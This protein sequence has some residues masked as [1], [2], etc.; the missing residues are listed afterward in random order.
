MPLPRFPRLEE[1]LGA[2]PDQLQ[3]QHLQNLVG[4]AAEDADLD[5]KREH[6]GNGDDSKRSLAQDVA[7]LANSRGGLILIGI[8]EINGVASAITPVAL[9]DAE[10]LR[11][12]QIV[13]TLVAPVAPFDMKRVPV[14]GAVDQG[15]LVLAVPPSAQRP[16]AVRV[17]DNLRY[18]SRDGSRNRALAETEVADAYRNRF[19]VA[20]AQVTRVDRIHREALDQL[21]LKDAV[22]LTLALVPNVP[23]AMS[24][25][26][27]TLAEAR[28][29]VEQF[30]CRSQ[31]D[32]PFHDSAIGIGASVRRVTLKSGFE[33]GPASFAY[34]ELHDDGSG[35][36]T[37]EVWHAWN[38]ETRSAGRRDI[39]DEHLVLTMSGLLA[40]LAVHAS[41]NA[42]AYGDAVLMSTLVGSGSGQLDTPLGL[43]HYRRFGTD[44]ELWSG[45]RPVYRPTISRG[46]FNIEALVTNPTE[47]MLAVRE[48]LTEQFQAF[49]L[50]EVPQ[51][52]RSG[53]LRLR[54]W[55][56]EALRGWNG[57]VG[58]PE[59][60]ATMDNDTE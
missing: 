45:T 3:E 32:G 5:F 1:L 41:K 2:A 51:I 40:L 52:G 22:W 35:F 57:R 44:W 43:G 11:L 15:V 4:R 50:A 46:T 20:E 48:M 16:H 54:Y 47:R 25:R 39:A 23:G 26:H 28:H 58:V 24:I 56:Q 27:R 30:L 6:Y 18:Y 8:D 36:A 29:W 34:A 53:H 59:S 14:G 33:P 7:A 60:Q 13:A 12:R 19:I 37:R 38:D 21:E 49:G 31:G 10:E 55:G 42:G 17:G 9:S